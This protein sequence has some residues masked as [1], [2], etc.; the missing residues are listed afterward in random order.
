M[1]TLFVFLANFTDSVE[2]TFTSIFLSVCSFT[3]TPF[4][5]TFFSS[6]LDVFGS[7]SSSLLWFFPSLHLSSVLCASLCPPY[8][9]FLTKGC[10]TSE[11]TLRRNGLGQLGF[12]VNYEGIVAEVSVC[13]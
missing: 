5:F 12:H 7:F 9:Q 3:A 11:M 4:L 10:E 8:V 6:P 2:D 13:T 1:K